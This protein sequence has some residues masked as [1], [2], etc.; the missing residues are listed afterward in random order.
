[1]IKELEMLVWST[2]EMMRLEVL[3]AGSL[4]YPPINNGCE[5]IP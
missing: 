3:Y 2:K 4:D 1:M 5:I